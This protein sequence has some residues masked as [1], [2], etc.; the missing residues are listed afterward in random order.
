MKSKEFIKYYNLIDAK[1]EG[2]DDRYQGFAEKVKN[3]TNK[4]I[5][6]Y[7]DDLLSYGELRNAIVHRHIDDNM[8]IADPHP[9]TV[10]NLKK[11]YEQITKP[12]RVIPTFQMDIIGAKEDEFI[13]DILKSIRDYSFS[14]FPVFNDANEV[15]EVINT[16]TIARWVA[17]KLTEDGGGLIVDAKVKDFI[18]D[19]EFEYNYKFMPRNATIYDAYYHFIDTIKE[20]KH[21]LD[22]LFITHSGKPTEKLLGMITIED[23][24]KEM[25]KM[26]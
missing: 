11:I 22:V 24:A 9:I 14:Q 26:E 15:I 13:N 6:N 10:T 16:N 18:D 21:N 2:R 20:K 12:K 23:I 1:L 19:I 17:N 3:S 7:K 5:R 8:P 25:A 4:V